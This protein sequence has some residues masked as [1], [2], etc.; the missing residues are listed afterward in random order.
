MT[1]NDKSS[2]TQS[3]DENATPA[4]LRADIEHTRA[5]LGQTVEALA[6]KVGLKSGAREAAG[7]AADKVAAQARQTFQAAR[8]KAGPVAQQAQHKARDFAGKARDTATSE[9]AQ[10]QVRGGGAAAAAAT[11]AV[12]LA[13]WVRRRRR[14]RRLTRWQ[15]TMRTAQ[16]TAAEL[17]TTV[18]DSEITAQAAAR[19]Q[20]AA[21][22][23]AARARQAAGDPGTR[24]RAQG[25]AAA[26]AA[27]LVLSCL[28]RSR[29][30]RRR[31]RTE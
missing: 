22:D 19:G 13:V 28:R 18:R 16:K 4:E 27:V 1:T 10:A 6:G 17:G 11:G 15:Q 20:A 21:A 14:A 5:N 3:T 31:D 23:L 25:A 12:L 7:K 24:P 9:D 30:A 8:H 2:N 29:A 26:I